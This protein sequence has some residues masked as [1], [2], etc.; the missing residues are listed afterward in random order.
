VKRKEKKKEGLQA[1]PY[2]V[3]PDRQGE[4][5]IAK[6]RRKVEKPTRASVGLERGH[7]ET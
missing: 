4:G 6:G 2:I 7:K 5:D 1:M 3:Q